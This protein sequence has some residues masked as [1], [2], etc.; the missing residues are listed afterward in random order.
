[1]SIRGCP[2]IRGYDSS[3]SSTALVCPVVLVWS[4]LIIGKSLGLGIFVPSTHVTYS[5]IFSIKHGHGKSPIEFWSPLSLGISQPHLEAILHGG[6]MV[7][8]SRPPRSLGDLCM[9]S[10]CAGDLEALG[11]TQKQTISD[12]VLCIGCTNI[13]IYICYICNYKRYYTRYIS[14]YILLGCSKWAQPQMLNFCG[15]CSFF[16]GCVRPFDNYSWDD[17]DSYYWGGPWRIT[18]TTIRT[19]WVSPVHMFKRTS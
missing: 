1:M 6:C 5:Y 12:R 17:W 13:Y 15:L 16:W 7:I 10:T 19:W 18:S 11:E 2:N 9:L 4:C 8:A 14:I 3:K